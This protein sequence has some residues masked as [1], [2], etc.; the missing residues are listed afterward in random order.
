MFAEMKVC[1]ILTLSLICIH[2]F[3]MINTTNNTN[4][5]LNAKRK[6]RYCVEINYTQRTGAKSG[7]FNCK[8]IMKVHSH[9]HN[10]IPNVASDKVANFNIYEIPTISKRVL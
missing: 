4:V 6:C 1:V 5:T 3:T 7:N 9:R 8:N 10:N 2:L